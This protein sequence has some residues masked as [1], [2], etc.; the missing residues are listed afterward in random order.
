MVKG[1]PRAASRKNGNSTKPAVS[2]LGRELRQ[3]AERIAAS[4]EKPL[5]RRELEREIANRR[6]GNF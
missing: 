5:N 2:K 4:G 6:A 1:A 3:I